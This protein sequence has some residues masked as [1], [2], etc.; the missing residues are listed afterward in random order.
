MILTSKLYFALLKD[1]EKF[2]D[3]KYWERKHA[4][5]HKDYSNSK[6]IGENKVCSVIPKT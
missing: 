4:G 2:I 5:C 1:K 6:E 3:R